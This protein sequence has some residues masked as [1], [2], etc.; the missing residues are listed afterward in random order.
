MSG[1]LELNSN[2]ASLGVQ[3]RLASSTEQLQRSYTRL[4]SGLRINRAAD[5]AAGM[6]VASGLN[7]D[8]RVYNQAIRNGNDGLS[9]LSIADGAVE[10]LGTA[11]IR[12]RELA[13]QSANGVI[14]SPQ[15]RALQGEVE[16]LRQEFNR[17]LQ[18]TEFNGRQLLDGSFTEVDLQLGY[19]RDTLAISIG[20]GFTATEADGTFTAAG[21]YST[22]DVPWSAV[23]GDLNGDGFGDTVTGDINSGQL[24]VRFGSADGTLSAAA[25]YAVNNVQGIS[26]SDVNEDGR[27]DILSAQFGLG[28]QVRLNDGSGGFASSTSYLMGNQIEGLV[29]ADFNHDGNLDAVTGEQDG[30]SIRLGTGTGTFG[31]VLSYSLGLAQVVD[32]VSGDFDNDGNHDIALSNWGGQ[33]I[34][35]ARGLGNGT[36][37]APISYTTAAAAFA[38]ST[39]DIDGDGDLDLVSSSNGNGNIEIFRNNG[40][41]S[42]STS[43]V[44][45]TGVIPGTT[46]S[47]L[48]NDG[49]SDLIA[50]TGAGAV[51]VFLAAGGGTF[52]P[53]VSYPFGVMSE[54]G[55]AV[56]DINGDGAK[57]LIA[58]TYSGGE[59]AMQVF[60]ANGVSA[61]GIAFIDVSTQAAAL[62]ALT[63]LEDKSATI[64]RER[65]RI[66]AQQSRLA[67]ALSNL[68]QGVENISAA[69]SEIRDVD[70]AEESALLVRS[71]ILQQVGSSLLA[72]ANQQP[73][74]LLQLLGR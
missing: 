45:G 35:L 31:A 61:A 17:I 72:Q 44:A 23:I 66:G 18:T 64:F 57:D 5:D 47:D 29:V 70:V 13:E 1:R 24:S 25:T 3:R 37:A 59:G 71:T 49:L 7:T 39:G 62:E 26:L 38:L 30:F 53:V 9:A 11:L 10:Q 40:G 41:L 63:I 51:N 6:A 55:I 73:Q 34:F 2:I 20:P 8:A 21:S 12:M 43:I 58:T 68:H 15:R 42:F 69:E 48:N 14:T 74:I 60:L 28:V 4:S 65:G 46:M 16:A 32:I 27:L 50:L 56:G 54:Q 67:A 52:Q 22:G 36:F 19:S 33:R